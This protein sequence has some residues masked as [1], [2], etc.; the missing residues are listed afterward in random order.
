M[1]PLIYIGI[2]HS[3]FI[4][5]FYLNRHPNRL[6]D[7]IVAIF[8]VFLAMPLISQLLVMTTGAGNPILL[9]FLIVDAYTL[10]YGPFLFIYTQTMI[11]EK[12]EL[13]LN[14]LIHFIPFLLFFLVLFFGSDP[15]L[16]HGPPFMRH[17]PGVIV[18]RSDLLNTIHGMANI[19]SFIFYSILVFNRL[20]KHNK[21]LED[22]FSYHS[23]RITLHWLQWIMVCFV[24]AYLTSFVLQ[25]DLISANMRIPLSGY[26]KII[27]TCFFI[28]AFS[29]FSLNQPLIYDKAD[30]TPQEELSKERKYEK[31]GLKADD[32]QDYLNKLERYMKEDRPYEDGDLTIADI[33]MKLQIPKH[34]IT[35]IINEKLDKNFYTYINE[36]RID[37]VKKKMEDRNFE[38][39]TIL[40]I[41]YECGF[42]S[43]SA[44][45]TIFK[46]FT[47]MSPSQYRKEYSTIL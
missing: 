24:L 29:F 25:L 40:S 27:G 6:S 43:K 17:N 9:K 35:Q 33:S 15:S 4:A 36:Y 23:H 5:F 19:V 3:I 38:D 44:F 7:R 32:A 37:E 16:R 22:Y 21:K 28:L 47:H 18:N 12:K 26:S 14:D 11:G 42:N 34:Y 31:S 41:A 20:K 46:K 10:T 39:Y 1:V 45:N 2:A 8:M 13:F 30:E